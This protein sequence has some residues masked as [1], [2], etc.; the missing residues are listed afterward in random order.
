M[1][2]FQ[3]NRMWR[4]HDLRP[5]YVVYA[6]LLF[7]PMSLDLIDAYRPPDLR[8]RH[9]FDYFVVEPIGLFLFRGVTGP[10]RPAIQ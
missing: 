5:R 2:L 3:R 7:Q 1:Q 9:F 6:G 4:S 8:I 10:P